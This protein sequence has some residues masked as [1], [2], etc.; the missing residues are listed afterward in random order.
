MEKRNPNKFTHPQRTMI[1]AVRYTEE[2]HTPAMPML[3]HE[4]R[5]VI[6][7]NDQD[8]ALQAIYD[9]LPRIECQGLCS[10]RCR[11]LVITELEYHQMGEYLGYLPRW[12][13]DKAH[14]CPMLRNGRCR[15]HAVRPLVCRL[16][17]YTETM[18]CPHGCKPDRYLT[19]EEGLE[20][21]RQVQEL[22]YGPIIQGNGAREG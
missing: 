21:W 10:N 11:E 20:L 3:D 15:V 2:H 1:A 7:Q 14:T 4:N 19:W 12:K 17:G 16:W 5:E 18:I 8:A 6:S 13:Y 22:S 9:S